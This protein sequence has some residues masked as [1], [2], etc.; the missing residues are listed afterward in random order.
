MS[1]RAT[2]ISC[3]VHF[4]EMPLPWQPKVSYLLP[5]YI[6]NKYANWGRGGGGRRWDI[7]SQSRVF[8]LF[9]Q[10]VKLFGELVKYR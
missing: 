4:L 6:V 5:T 1:L 2:E 3:M 9:S 10:L 8:I 7:I